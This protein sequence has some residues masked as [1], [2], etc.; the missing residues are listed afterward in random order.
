MQEAG[1]V[2][3]IVLMGAF[4][5]FAG[6]YVP[7]LH[8]GEEVNNFFRAKNMLGGILTPMSMWAIMAIGATCVIIAG[9]IDISIASIFGLAA[10]G[11]VAILQNLPSD[12]GRWVTIPVGFAVGMAIGTLCGLI[13]GAL[14]VGLRMHPFIVTLSTMSIFRGICNVAVPMKTLPI[15]PMHVPDSFT[16]QFMMYQPMTGLQPMPTVVMVLCALAGWFYL[17]RTVAGRENYAIG[18]NEEAA[19]FSGLAV[20]RIKMRVYAISGLSAGIAGT[21]CAGYYGSASSNT[22]L[23]WELMV[24]AAAVVG[25]ASLS[26]GRGTALGAL[27]GAM[28]IKMIENGIEIMQYDKEYSMIIVGAAIVIAVAIDQF[29]EYLQ[30]SRAFSRA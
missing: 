17:R 8:T 25:G 23:G 19:R 26:G 16:F 18:G 15:Q 5:T 28:I 12:A 11:T 4:L 7:D 13:N 24:I 29:S 3:V 27:L 22:A 6:G 2:V 10:L 21:V 14:V 1:L 20:G 30:R 9:G